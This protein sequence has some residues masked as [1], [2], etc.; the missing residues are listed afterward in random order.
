M[1]AREKEIEMLEKHRPV[2]NQITPVA[3][4]IE[5]SKSGIERERKKEGGIKRKKAKSLRS[6]PKRLKR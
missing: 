6:L 1:E 4:A 5:I 2:V 3:Q